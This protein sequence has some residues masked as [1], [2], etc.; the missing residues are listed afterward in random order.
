MTDYIVVG[1]GSAGCVLANRLSSDPSVRVTLLEAG[2]WDRSP[3][4]GMP[5]GYFQLMKTGQVDWGYHTEPQENLS[6]RT[7]FLPRA[8]VLG[9]CSCVNGMIYI[10]GSATD[11]DH[12]ASLGNSGWS[13]D[14]CLP[15]FLRAENWN[16]PADPYHGVGGPLYTSRHGIRH[17]LSKA[18]IEAGKQAGYAYKDDFNR[19][20]LEGFGPCDSTLKTD[21]ENGVRSS[22][23]FSYI[24]P[25]KN[26]PNLTVLTRALVTRV[27]IENGRAVGVEYLKNGRKARLRADREIILSGGSINSPQLLQLSGIGEPD[28]LLSLG[29]KVEAP[30]VG[31]G[32]NLQDHL[33]VGVQT[34]CTQPITL[35]PYVKP[36]KAALALARYIWDKG[37]PGAYHGIE[38]LAFVKSRPDLVAPDI[39]YHFEMIMYR[40]HGREIIPEHG[41]TPYLNISRPKSRGWLKIRSTDPVQH[42]VIQPNYFS[43]PDDIRVFREGI[44]IGRDIVAQSAFDPYRG[45]EYAPGPEAR[46]DAQIDAYLRQNVETIYHPVGTCKMGSDDMAVVDDRLRVH[47]VAGLRV[48]DASIMPTLVSGNTNAPAIMIAEKAA[49]LILRDGADRRGSAARPQARVIGT[50][51][52]L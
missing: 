33:A 4:I 9:G 22:A 42:P 24:H 14:D 21:G 1:G 48:A 7:L 12:W 49:D 43:D 32:Q 52:R 20:D 25:V 46:T 23:A 34:R 47:G 45:V 18:F 37:G 39:Q 50:E 11:Y 6:G 16:G 31:V 35:L 26:R 38:A 17:P 41:F 44:R 30:L 2:G 13:F 3:F 27:L 15:Y 29:I 19:G 10:R 28:H 51:M 36:V 40:D 5:A 8:K